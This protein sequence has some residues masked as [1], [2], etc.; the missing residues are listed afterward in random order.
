MQKYQY[1]RFLSIIVYTVYCI[2]LYT[3]SNESQTRFQEN[4]S[5]DNT[6]IYTVDP[7]LRS[8]RQEMNPRLGSWDPRESG[9]PGIPGGLSRSGGRDYYSYDCYT[10]MWIR[11]KN[12]SQTRILGSKRVWDTCWGPPGMNPR[13]KWRKN[14]DRKSRRFTAQ[15]IW[16]KD[17]RP[18]SW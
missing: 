7:R 6:G 13:L 14:W 12:E 3:L 5:W 2:Y 18:D 11:T 10:V 15:K 4:E 16:N 17:R 8:P 1:I 9:I